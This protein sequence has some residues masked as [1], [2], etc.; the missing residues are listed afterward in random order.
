MTASSKYGIV[1]GRFQP[2]HLGHAEY[3]T[4]AKGHCDRLVIGITNPDLRG[5]GVTPEDPA[6]SEQSNN[7][8]TY[9]QRYTMVE[10]SCLDDGWVSEDFDIVPA[11]IN[12]LDA[13][14]QYLPPSDESTFFVT[15]YDQWGEAKKKKL[16]DL[17]FQVEI[18]W[19][20]TMDQR[21]TSGTAIRSEI[22]AGSSTW[23]EYVSPSVA[24]LLTSYRSA[25]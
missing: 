1:L 19:R 22:R 6:R 15:I 4:V 12:Q 20:R 10:A 16:E 21:L 25:L 14:P 13:L 2:I 18:L 17:G 3:L 11:P 5:L 8:F 7:P 9:Y 24:K 23:K